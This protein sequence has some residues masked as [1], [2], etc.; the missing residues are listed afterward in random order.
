MIEKSYI[1]L[2]K[3]WYNIKQIFRIIIKCNKSI[4]VEFEWAIMS[5]NIGHVDK[6]LVQL[7]MA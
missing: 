1:Q 4:M 2:V 3:Q 6:K 7:R 5:T